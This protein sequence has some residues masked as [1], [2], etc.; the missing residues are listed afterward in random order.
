[1]GKLNVISGKKLISIFEQFGWIVVRRKGSHIIMIKS[2]E[3]VTLSIPDHD[4]VAKGTLRSLLRTASITI[5]EYNNALS[6]K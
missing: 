4:E 3:H 1:M 5:E 2:G 6:K